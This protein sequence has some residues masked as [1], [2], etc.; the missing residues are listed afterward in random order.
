MDHIEILYD[1]ADEN[2]RKMT[3]IRV[4]KRFLNSIETSLPKRLTRTS[5]VSKV[6]EHR[7]IRNNRRCREQSVFSNRTQSHQHLTSAMSQ[8]F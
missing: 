4:T 3:T 6:T 2:I 8:I 1:L 7:R 5:G